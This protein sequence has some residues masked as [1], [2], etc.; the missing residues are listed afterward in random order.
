MTASEQSQLTLSDNTLILI[1]CDEEKIAQ[2]M[3][4]IDYIFRQC[5]THFI[6][7]PMQDNELNTYASTAPTDPTPR[8]YLRCTIPP[9][10]SII[11]STV[12]HNKGNTGAP[13][14]PTPI[15]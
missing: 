3:Y 6:R 1:G 10:N 4:I 14:D 2:G 8:S 7:N 11:E 9:T 5:I 12:Q 13:T 15:N